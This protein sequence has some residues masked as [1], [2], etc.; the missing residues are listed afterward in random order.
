[1]K[2]LV[3]I[4]S[5]RKHNTHEIA[6]MIEKRHKQLSDCEYEYIFLK[7]M[8]LKLCTGCHACM[9]AGEQYCPL[10]DD[11][12][13]IIGKMEE[14]DGIIIASPTFSMNVPWV[15]KN[16]MDRLSY[17][18]HR[19]RLFNQKIMLMVLSGSIRG[20]KDAMRA[21][22]FAA[23][24]G[25]VVNKL[26]VL[27]SPDMNE[28]K[29]NKQDKIVMR[30]AE[31]FAASMNKKYTHKPPFSYLIWF[32]AFKALSKESKDS[33]RADHAYYKDKNYFIDIRLSKPQD[34]A[35]K[36]FTGL[37]TVLI[38]KGFV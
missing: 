24:A 7:D 14:A 33:N 19:P 28:N 9:T 34:V 10:K 17:I 31:K 21:L 20:G 25:K 22:S 2:I 23:F 38:K 18:M 5:L 11:R 13:M 3:L 37:F 29:R 1:M 35:V 36:I 16:F 26:I 27:N 12:D 4:G 15:M 32:S 8:D 30:E 6:K